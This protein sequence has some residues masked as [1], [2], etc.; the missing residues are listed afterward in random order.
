MTYNTSETIR[1]FLQEKRYLQNVSPRTIILYESCLKAFAEA[2]GSIEDVKKRVVELRSRGISPVTVNTYLRHVKCF[3]LWQGREWT[4]P[5][6][7][8]EEKLLK[9]LSPAQFQALLHWRPEGSRV[10]N[11]RRAHLIALTILS[12]GLRASEVLSVLKEDIDCDQLVIK[13][14]GKGGKERQVPFCT[15]L[16]KALWRH[17]VKVSPFHFVFGTNRNTKLSVRNFERDLKILGKL[18]G[19]ER[20]HPHGLRHCFE[21][22]YNGISTSLR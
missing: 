7:K 2:M 16:R 21:I 6:L 18:V 8:E 12:T 11:L 1:T 20:L 15:E 9:V 5:W 14:R 4:I 19:I 17:Y 13:V 10:R 3:Y 22:N